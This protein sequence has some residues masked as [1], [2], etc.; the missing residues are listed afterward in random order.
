M[1][2][3]EAEESDLKHIV[4]MLSD[5]DLGQTRERYETPLPKEYSGAFNA[6]KRQEGN[7]I[8]LAE[9]SGEVFGCM[10]LTI[11]PGL[12]RLGMKRAQIES[13][14][15]DRAHRGRKIGE[16]LFKEAIRIEEENYCGLVQLTTD[17][18]RPDALRFYEKLGFEAS[19]EGMKL[20][21]IKDT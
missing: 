16:A 12:S 8:I 1:H 15:I 6:V 5:D 17:K 13:V 9:E 19:H 10:Q 21:L 11:I 2:F 7:S 4:R 18:Q 20:S 14:R 3:R